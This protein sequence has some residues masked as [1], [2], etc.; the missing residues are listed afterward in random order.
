MQNNDIDF[1]PNDI[2]KTCK[3][4][5]KG[6]CFQLWGLQCCCHGSKSSP[7]IVSTEEINNG[8][9]SYDLI[10][11]RKKDLFLGINGKKNIDLGGCKGCSHLIEKKYKDVHF[12][13][14]GGEYLP[15][16]FNIQHYT[17]CNEKCV[18]CPYAQENKFE[19]PQYDILQIWEL[20]RKKRKLKGNNWIDFS[21]GEP[22][23][24][25]NFNEIIDYIYK[26]KMGFTVVFSNA[27]IFSQSIYDKLRCNKIALTTSIDTGIKSKY[28][29]IK[30]VDKYSNVISNLVQYRNSGTKK[31]WIKYVI[32]DCNQTEDDMW[33]FIMAMLAIRPNKIQISPEFPYGDKQISVETVKYAAK[34]W[35]NLEMYCGKIV[36]DGVSAHG[37]IKIV[38]YHKQLK[39]EFDLLKT[40]RPMKKDLR[41]KQFNNNPS[42]ILQFLKYANNRIPNNKIWNSIRYYA[43]KI[44]TSWGI[45]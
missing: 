1:Q 30:G 33:S 10:V 35:Y 25:K 41:L 26:N 38:Q 27:T 42:L 45:Y 36:E 9:V 23:I 18:Y 37:D 3:Y 5:E 19:I 29:E 16:A 14:I 4:L 24:L 44:L 43:G 15:G 34:L 7:V 28:A 11:Q 40:K 21:G 32:T 6:L 22:A 39:K 13:Y 8:S 12:D 2:V 20:F 17:S 31:L